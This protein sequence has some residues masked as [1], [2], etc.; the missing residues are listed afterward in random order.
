MQMETDEARAVDLP[1][2]TP[3]PMTS[4]DRTVI[5]RRQVTTQALPQRWPVINPL[6][7]GTPAALA[8]Y[9]RA[10][11]RR[12]ASQHPPSYFS[13]RPDPAAASLRWR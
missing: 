10:A 7:T 6:N 5:Q 9:S 13:G 3:A 11:N 2:L 8:V 4:S 12:P 1:L